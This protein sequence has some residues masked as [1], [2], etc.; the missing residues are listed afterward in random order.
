MGENFVEPVYNHHF[1]ARVTLFVSPQTRTRLT[2]KEE[3]G[4]HTLG[5]STH[6]IISNHFGSGVPLVRIHPRY[7]LFLCS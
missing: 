5:Y 1:A 3:T 6:R 4:T 2:K 7:I